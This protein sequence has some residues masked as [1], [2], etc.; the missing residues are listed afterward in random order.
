MRK[1]IIVGFKN[2]DVAD[3][4]NKLLDAYPDGTVV[5]PLQ[6]NNVPLESIVEACA[7]KNRK[8]HF[9]LPEFEEE[10]KYI[11]LL[12]HDVTH[13]TNPIKEVI[14]NV[15]IEDVIGIVWDDSIE[16]HMV[17]HS[18]EDYGL[19]IWNI[20]NGLEPIEIDNSDSDDLYE[21]MQEALS[22]FVDAFATYVSAGILETMTKTVEAILDEQMDHKDID[23]FEE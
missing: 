22:N 11:G 18:V 9:Y 21:D 16:A 4:I 13:C 17:L 19:D 23:P 8:M 3:G 20:A 15:N 1:I 2:L 5:I 12:G 6:G 14:R 7:D 10:T